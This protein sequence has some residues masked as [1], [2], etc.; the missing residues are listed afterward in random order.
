MDPSLGDP[1]W[2]GNLK[3]LTPHSLAS[4]HRVGWR[5]PRF[6]DRT[7]E[8]AANDL[9]LASKKQ[10]SMTQLSSYRG[11][12]REEDAGGRGGLGILKRR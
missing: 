5:T 3:R 9:L 1:K 2:E 11:A 12:A 4:A 8:I 6:L 7:W 10:L